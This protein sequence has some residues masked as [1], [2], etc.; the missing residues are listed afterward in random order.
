LNFSYQGLSRYKF[1]LAGKVPSRKK[2]LP[3]FILI[4]FWRKAPAAKEDFV[5][6]ASALLF[7]IEDFGFF[8]LLF[9]SALRNPHSAIWRR[10][11]WQ[12]RGEEGAPFK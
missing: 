3:F 5:G 6:K 9:Q 2:F 10:D 7:Q 11:F 12:G 8:C 4:A 1:I